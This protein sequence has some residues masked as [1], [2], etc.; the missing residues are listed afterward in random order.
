MALRSSSGTTPEAR[1][2]GPGDSWD[3]Q[4]RSSP[5]TPIDNSTIIINRVSHHARDAQRI[6]TKP[7]KEAIAAS[8]ILVDQ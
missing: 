3:S 8:D 1:Y 2:D 5:G 4:D 6:P 7:E